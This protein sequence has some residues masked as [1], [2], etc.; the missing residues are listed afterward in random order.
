[1][2]SSSQPLALSR[3]TLAARRS[4]FRVQFYFYASLVDNFYALY[5]SGLRNHAVK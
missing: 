5:F 1:M 3:D 2:V 4:R